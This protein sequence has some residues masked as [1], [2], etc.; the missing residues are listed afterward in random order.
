ML[1]DLQA[2]E[3]RVSSETK[4]RLVRARGLARLSAWFAFGHV[5]CDVAGYTLEVDQ[6][7]QLWQSDAKPSPDFTLSSNGPDGDRLDTDGDAVAVAISVSGNLEADI[8]GHL[9]HRKQK[10]RA[11]LFVRP[12][13]NLDRH[14]L[15]DAGDAVAL[16]DQAKSL[17]RDFAKRHGAK[18]LLLYYFG[19]LSGACFIGHRLNA[20]C[21][22]VQI[23]EWSEPN[24]I[25][26]FTLA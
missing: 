23:M 16:A 15:R 11:V 25:P 22:E 7:G 4:K 26:S 2:L 17:M 6:H 19:P 3:A 9:Q 21:R 8:R 12:T 1:P 18:R 10:L 24:Y 20:V 5:F 14:C 13:C